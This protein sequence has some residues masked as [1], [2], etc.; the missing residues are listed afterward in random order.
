MEVVIDCETDGLAYE[1]T[2]IHVLSWTEDGKHY[3]STNDRD[4]MADMLSSVG[5]RFVCHNSI[6]FDMVIFNR[7]LGLSL[8]YKSFVDTLA[9]SWYLFP[10]RNKHGLEEWGVDLGVEK[11]KVTDWKNLTYEEYKYR[12]EEDVKINWLLWQKCKERFKE[13]YA[14]NS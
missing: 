11:P 14:S 4:T 1:A 12:C 10:D 7:L 9:L 5:V 13:I 2:K 3:H 8:G 6:R